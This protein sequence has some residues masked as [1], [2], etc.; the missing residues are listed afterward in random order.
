MC[1]WTSVASFA[2]TAAGCCKCPCR[3][4]ATNGC[5]GTC[6]DFCASPLLAVPCSAV[7]FLCV[8]TCRRS[9]PF[10]VKGITMSNFTADEAQFMVE[11]GNKV[12]QMGGGAGQCSGAG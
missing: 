3:A 9:I 11:H 2:P 5:L 12:R 1:V 10:R 8:A 6:N 7:G 4:R